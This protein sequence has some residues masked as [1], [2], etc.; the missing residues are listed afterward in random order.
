MTL[1]TPER[2]W[3]ETIS[4]AIS[5]AMVV[6]GV[7]FCLLAAVGVV[8]MPDVY[9]RMQAATKAGTLGVMCIVLALP[10]R[11]VGEPGM[12]PVAAFALL[13]VAFIVLTGPI[14]SHLIA[15]AAYFD[16]DP[17]WE[18]TTTDELRG[19]YDPSTH[20]L[21]ATPKPRPAGEGSRVGRTSMDDR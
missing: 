16:D 17:V 15:R 12:L 18:Q 9:T 8:R 20:R 3:V 21:S 13:I 4:L 11:L 6:V 7:V 14:A 19:C 2:V 1:P 10:V 5:D